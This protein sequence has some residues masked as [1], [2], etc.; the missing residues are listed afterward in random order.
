MAIKRILTP[1]ER[2]KKEFKKVLDKS[3]TAPFIFAG[4]GLSIRYYN[5]PTWIDLLESFVIKHKELFKHEFGYY[6]SKVS[7]NPLKIASEL[8]D[9]FHEI[10]W[11]EDQF[12]PNREL[13]KNIATKNKEV[14][15]KI[16]LCEF[17]KEKVKIDPSIQPE[18][19]LLKS[20]VLSGIMTTNWDDFF[21]VNFKDFDTKIGQKEVLFSDQHAI[22][23]IY[24]IHGCISQPDSLIVTQND[25]DEFEKNSHY[26]RSKILTLFLDFPIIFIGYSISDPNIQSI[27]QNI[28]SSLDNDYLKIEKLQNRLFFVEWHSEECEPSIENSNYQIPTGRIPIKKIKANTYEAIFEVLSSIPRKL[29]VNILR[30]LKGM[31][32]DFVMTKEPTGRIL[33]NGIEDLDKIENLEVV[34]GFGNISKLQDK[35]VTGISDTE[36]FEDILFETISFENYREIVEKLLNKSVRKN[37]Y[38]PFFKYNKLIGNLNPDNS[39]K[40]NI[41]GNWVLKRTQNISLVDYKVETPRKRIERQI[42]HFKT[43]QDLIDGSDLNHAVQ[44]I[45]YFNLKKSDVSVLKVFLKSCWENKD[46]NQSYL[47]HYRKCICILDFL[48]NAN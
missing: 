38:I 3:N 10:W 42:A 17:I 39:L 2:F 47:T 4:S 44:R 31:V 25:Y 26:L 15:F 12:T 7:S 48:E 13:Y 40:E 36:L 45:P 41:N 29:P 46:L 30:Q 24:K 16:E 33:V 21:Q 35:G 5:I 9:E 19:D 18:V 14:S 43:L 11:K 20:S 6:S 8:A 37:K 22:G 28:I 23:E 32:Y 27:L 34:V 1:T